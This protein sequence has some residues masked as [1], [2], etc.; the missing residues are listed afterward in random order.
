MTTT[1]VGKIGHLPKSIRDQLNRRLQDGQTGTRLVKWLNSL[2]ETKNALAADF[3]GRDI[4]EVNLTEWKQ[5]GFQDWLASQE[6]R[7]CAGNVA[8]EGQELATVSDGSLANHLA[9]VLSAQYAA[10]MSGWKGEIND[11]FQRQARA[12]GLLCHGIAQLRRGN[13]HL[14]R[15][16]LDRERFA[17]ANT[18]DQERALQL[19]LAESKQWPDVQQA[20]RDAFVLRYQ[21]KTGKPS[22]DQPETDPTKPNSP[23]TASESSS[24][25]PN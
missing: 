25:K 23:E 2:P 9:A 11:D 3:G 12:L 22:P 10:L 15:L 24:I 1:R 16:Q 7:A 20:V 5:G 8:E 21:R 4:N 13:Y 14:D 18:A 6:L 19:C 17:E